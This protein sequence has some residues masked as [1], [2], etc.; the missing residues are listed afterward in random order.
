MN[1]AVIGIGYVGLVTA[2]CLSELGHNVYC[3]N[4]NEE[5]T[6]NLK[7]GIIS[8]YEP[9]L[10]ELVVNNLKKRRIF[11]TTDLKKGIRNAKVVFITVQTPQKKDGSVDLSYVYKV[12]GQI[13]KSMTSYKVIVDKSTVPVGTSKKVKAIIK[14]HYKKSFGVVSCPEFLR[15]GK[16]VYDFFKPD[17][18]IVGCDDNKSCEIMK[19]IFRRIKVKKVFTKVENAELIK[20]AS[21]AFLATKISFI[22]EISNI[23]EMV[24]TDVEVVADAM[25]LDKRIGRHFLY[26][27]IGYGGSCFPKD[28]NALNQMSGTHGYDFKLL[29]AVINVN[30]YQR[31]LMVE[32]VK[33]AIPRLKGK[34]IT[35]FGLAFKPG[36]DDTRE[37]A[38]IYI[39]KRLQ[40]LGVKI[41]AYDPIAE[42]NA[43]KDLNH[44]VVFWRDPYDACLGS[45]AVIITTEWK[46]FRELNWQKIKKFL[47]KPIIL[48]G[49]NIL[50]PQKMKEIGFKY[51]GMGRGFNK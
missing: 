46:K 30:N 19:Q 29:K 48:D 4:R 42:K 18:I 25:G 43:A 44:E 8:I 40:D 3:I 1:L 27:G 45:E 16:A 22:N 20:Y 28:V 41:S 51:Q 14:R 37:S 34:Q 9:G 2:A 17:R 32:K 12:A 13:G 31:N 5:K 23:C 35:V 33:K 49:R 39:I 26:A 47:K 38:S 50:D 15:E 6:D 11:F 10:K 36:T 7:K 21:N 24:G